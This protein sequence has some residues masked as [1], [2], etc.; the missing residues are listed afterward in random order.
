MFRIEPTPPFEKPWDVV[1]EGVRRGYFVRALREAG[2]KV[3][4]EAASAI[5]ELYKDAQQVSRKRTSS[6]YGGPRYTADGGIG[7]I[8]HSALLF[9]EQ[10]YDYLARRRKSCTASLRNTSGGRLTLTGSRKELAFSHGFYNRKR[11]LG[12]R[13]EFI[14][15]G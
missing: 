9:I 15:A 2:P 11:A 1:N 13:A 7:G 10:E 6:V 4:L 12:N 3:Q 5:V 14:T 8:R